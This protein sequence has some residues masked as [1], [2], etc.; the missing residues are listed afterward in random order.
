MCVYVVPAEARRG[1]LRTRVTGGK[2]HQRWELN[3]GLLEEQYVLLSTEPSLQP[4]HGFFIPSLTTSF[5]RDVDISPW[6]GEGTQVKSSS[7]GL[8]GTVR[9]DKL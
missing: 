3:P 9:V 8:V 6:L 5:S 7:Q 1:H 4:P 2:P